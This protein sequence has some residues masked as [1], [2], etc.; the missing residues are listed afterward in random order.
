MSKIG[1]KPIDLNNTQVEIV[2]QEIKYKGKAS[3]GTHVLPEFLKAQSD[4]KQLKIT[5][6]GDQGEKKFWGLHRALLANKIKA[7]NQNFERKLQI[8][9]LGFKAESI[10]AGKIRFS[11]GFSHKIEKVL[12]KEVTLEIDKTGQMLTFKSF[13]KQLLGQ[14]CADI[15][16]LRPPEPYKGTGIKFEEEVIFRKAGK[17]KAV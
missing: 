4:G 16:S 10:A 11:L 12:P 2:G 1:R 14:V 5:M 15:R 13:D 3:S 7:A 6:V 17:T 8:N 9:G